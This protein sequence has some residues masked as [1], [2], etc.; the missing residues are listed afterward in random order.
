MYRLL[1]AKTNWSDVSMIGEILG[2]SGVGG[3][4]MGCSCWGGQQWKTG[5]RCWLSLRVPEIAQPLMRSLEL[6][7]K[8]S[9]STATFSK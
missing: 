9:K 5:K 3:K 4:R 6:S 2:V 8:V 1:L 7:L